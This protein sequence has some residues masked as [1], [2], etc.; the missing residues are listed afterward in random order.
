MLA[1][2]AERATGAAV[3][4]LSIVIVLYNSAAEIGTCLESVSSELAS[5]WAELIVVDNA[6]GDD[7]AE[8]V[9]TLVPGARVISQSRNLGF[10]RGVNAALA[11]ARGRY[12]LLLNPDVTAPSGGLRAL[13]AW[14][15]A[16]P[17]LAAASPDIIDAH[18]RGSEAAARSFPA[19]WRTALEL[20][21]VHRLLPAGLRSRLLLGAYWDGRDT[22]TAD[23]V[24]GT[25]MLVRAAVI[26]RVGM[27]SPTFFMYGEDIEWCWR[28]RRAGYRVGV[29]TGVSFVHRG[30]PSSTNAWGVAGR[31]R[32]VILGCHAANVSMHG[33][34]H[35]RAIAAATAMAL[36]LESRSP[37]RSAQQRANAAAA[38]SQWLRLALRR[39]PG[40]TS[41]SDH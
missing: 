34:A 30:S 26:A 10:A 13:V 8:I 35:A 17:H 39:S 25:A 29:H 37:G 21:R 12:V 4:E 36:W 32:R 41:V 38:A 22:E 23:W 9:R 11:A 24:P 18:S 28:M 19:A 2:E 40:L 6:S 7:G 31:A 3:A 16:R 5:G 15:D 14:M 27:L 1:D 33:A 20:S